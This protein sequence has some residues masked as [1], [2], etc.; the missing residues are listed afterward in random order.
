[1]DV[2]ANTIEQDYREA[3]EIPLGFLFA[4][5]KNIGNTPAMVN[6]VALAPGEAKGYPFVGKPHAAKP[7]D[8]MDSTLRVM[9]VL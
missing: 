5:V 1:M 4:S 3:G 7:F 8:P 9:Y 2:L 6:N